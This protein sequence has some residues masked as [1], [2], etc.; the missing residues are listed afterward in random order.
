[1]A[2][3][4]VI[5]ESPTKARTVGRFLGKKYI[6]MASMGHVRDLPSSKLGVE[7]EEGFKPTYVI[8]AGKKKVIKEFKAALKDAKTVYL[9]TD[10][11]REGEAISWH[12]LQAVN[13]KDQL[14]RR[15]VFHEI[16]PAA[17]KEA[18]DHPREL[19]LDLVNAQQ[20]RRILDR[21]LGYQLSPLLWSKVG[22]GLSAGRVQSVAL[23]II[24]ERARSIR[25]F[26]AVEYWS[27][28]ATLAKQGS[29]A[30]SAIFKATLHSR[31]GDKKKLTISN[32]TEAAGIVGDLA[33][34]TYDVTEVR[35]KE[36]KS[37]PAGPFTTSTLQQE[38]GRKLR[39]PVRKTMMIAQQLYEG[40]G[41]G[42]EG[43]VGLITYMRTDSTNLSESAVQ[44]AR[45]Y[46]GQRYGKE[47]VPKSARIYK[48]RAK[49]AQEAH[50]AIRPTSAI[51][52]PEAIRAHLT[53]DQ[54]R[55]YDLIWKRMVAC[56][57]AD[58]VYDSTSAD[59]E[60]PGRSGTAYIFRATGSVLKF[61]G[62]R[63][64]YIEG[65]DAGDE[66]DPAR[67]PLPV[68][69]QGE[70]VDLQELKPEQHFTQPPPHYTEASLVK[71]LEELGI[72]RPSTYAPTISTI[73]DRNYVR[74]NGHLEP[75]QLGEIVNDLLV[76]NFADLVNPGF[77]AQM[78]E[79]LDDVAQGNRGWD[80]LLTEFYG[81]FQDALSAAQ[82]IPRISIPSDEICETCGKPMEIKSG[83][84][85]RFLACT[86]YPECK[87][88]R[89]YLI[90]VG[91]DCPR[92][93][94]DLVERRSR[95]T[96]ALFYG[97]SNYPT[98]N[99]A[100]NQK[101]IP[102]P[103]PECEGLLI[104]AGRNG[105]KCTNCAFKAP[106][107]EVQTTTEEPEPEPVAVEA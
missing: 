38:A 25:D 16:T 78:E 41:V 8:P 63:A 36:T 46:I 55:L 34:A 43:E 54:Y 83:R 33:G 3:E 85:G 4:L 89:P 12:L 31:K 40:V 101:P 30:K 21:L 93:G 9:A 11:D 52:D 5:V 100:A 28:D 70:T 86:G 97:C 73:Q 80:T 15:V 64:V 24:V 67:S 59:I 95:K 27:I 106:L 74:K 6:V 68:L 57:M 13:L 75:T 62:Y 88:T 87:T 37:R 2:K 76:Q 90:R 58:A 66:Q 48:T 92:C 77:T 103:C 96:K 26:V 45:Q 39:F 99:F 29:R 65:R 32:E 82:S 91:V 98:C 84:Y 107:S 44:E 23:R 20:A 60:A 53:S 35:R 19:D 79:N 1:M 71:S 17:I 61:P 18:F 42:A 47:Y 102:E 14:V 10:P 50:E 51:R 105:V 49:A 69:N 7:V 94:G 22:S 104:M 72:G 56:Q 81:P